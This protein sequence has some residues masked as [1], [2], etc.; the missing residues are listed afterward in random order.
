MNGL[1]D[2]DS[3]V[4]IRIGGRKFFRFLQFPKSILYVARM[5]V[6]KPKILVQLAKSSAAAT[7]LNHFLQL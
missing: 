6:D 2:A 1:R 7:N 3:L 4:D 5:K